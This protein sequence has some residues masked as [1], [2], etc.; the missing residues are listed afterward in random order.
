MLN[1]DFI[2]IKGEVWRQQKPGKR[3][4]I[5]VLMTMQRWDICYIFFLVCLSLF[6]WSAVFIT[7]L[8]SSA[9]EWLCSV[10]V[11]TKKCNRRTTLERSEENNYWEHKSVFCFFFFFFFFFFFCLS[12]FCHFMSSLVHCCGRLCPIILGI[13]FI[14]SIFPLYTYGTFRLPWRP[15]LKSSTQ[16][17]VLLNWVRIDSLVEEKNGV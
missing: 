8:L 14:L 12:R 11:R 15:V 17:T 1:W 7:L 6:R 13:L 3:P 4:T 10:I 2:R 16:A 5:V 9:F